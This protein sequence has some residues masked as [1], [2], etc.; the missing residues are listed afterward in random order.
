MRV[1]TGEDP[2]TAGM[3]GDGLRA[4]A[5]LVEGEVGRAQVLVRR[6]GVV[7]LDRAIRCRA[8]AL[9]LLFSAGKPFTAVLVHGLA[10]DG[11]VD[12]DRPLADCWPELAAHGKGAI[13]W[14]QVLQHRSGLP[15]VG[16]VTRDALRMTSW[17][18]SVR[19]IERA[20]LRFPPGER[21]AYQ[22][23]T[24]G[25]LLGEGVRRTLAPESPVDGA[26]VR[27]ALL[28]RVTGPVGLDDVHLGLPPGLGARVVRVVPVGTRAV[29]AAAWLNRPAVRAAV[30]PAATVHGT[31]GD[32]A[33]FYDALLAPV[34]RAAAPALLGPAQLA[35]AT[36]LSSDGEIDA[37]LHAPVRWSAGF[38]LG[39]PVPDP[40]RPRALGRTTS[41]G[42]F[43][44]NGSYACVGWADPERDLV[45]ALVTDRL[46]TPEWGAAFLDEVA[47]RVVA[48]CR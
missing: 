39:G 5:E 1:G 36:A 44:H 26:A 10:Q 12:L 19:A 3:S 7:A 23:L 8:D 46:P 16:G 20:R 38:Q 47:A 18:D 9:F 4:V 28:S 14:R 6:S 31:A 27:A 35:E 22:T 42:T 48:A 13:T 11:V 25:F 41:P 30:V 32:L 29:T 43:G 17:S 40:A 45:L 24:Q 21:P 34:T 37:T 15:A 2:R 33:A